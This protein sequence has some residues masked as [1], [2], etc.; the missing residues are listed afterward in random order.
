M[1]ETGI[2]LPNLD[3]A[4]ARLRDQI[5]SGFVGLLTDEQWQ[6]MVRA[7]LDKF[8]KPSTETDF[9]GNRK[10]D[11]PSVLETLC[12]EVF[13]EQVKKILLEII[14]EPVPGSRDSHDPISGQWRPAISKV[15]KEWLTEN[16][17]K[18][19][20]STVHALAGESAMRVFQM[21]AGR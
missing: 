7:E 21:M 12:R 16:T 20:I 4:A 17:E 3:D 10:V 13:G 15:L 18:L 5:R 8:T 11:K 6:A 1:A 2:A 19:I 9:Y 14:A